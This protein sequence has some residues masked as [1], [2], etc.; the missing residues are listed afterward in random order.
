MKSLNLK[1]SK[2]EK[3]VGFLKRFS[4]IENSLLVELESGSIKAKSHT[5]EK[6]VVKYSSVPLDE[7][8]SEY[9][10]IKEL[11]KFGIYNID[12]FAT[13]CNFFGKSEFDF[14]IEYESVAGENIGTR[15]TLK[16]SLLT[17]GIDCATMK[18]FT[19]ISDDILNKITDTKSAHAEFTLQ[20]DQQAKLISLFGIDSDSSKISFIK[21]GTNIFAKGK[22]FN[23][24]LVDDNAL[25][26]TNDTEMS[27]FKHHYI[28]LDKEDANVYIVDDKLVFLSNES[29]TKMIIGEAE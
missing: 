4:S 11:V 12:K 14:I 2:V 27:I 24:Q 13:S 21:K 17:I 16:N 22:S 15:I 18:V 10:D 1:V 5:P 19:Y 9:S 28:F 29:D 6:S 8:F 25:L 7:I 3:L 20:K 23:L 26:S